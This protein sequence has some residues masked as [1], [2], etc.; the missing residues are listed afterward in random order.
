MIILVDKVALVTVATVQGRKSI[1]YIRH[2]WIISFSKS[3]EASIVS[4]LRKNRQSGIIIFLLHGA[5]KPI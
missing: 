1:T 3:K 2:G 5:M 4:H